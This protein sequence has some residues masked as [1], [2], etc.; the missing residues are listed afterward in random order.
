[1]T[2][3]I[4]VFFLITATMVGAM[5]AR[6]ASDDLANEIAQSLEEAPAEEPVLIAPPAPPEESAQ[7]GTAEAPLTTTGL[8]AE[9]QTPTGQFTTA[10]EVKPILSM[11][12]QSWVAVREYDGKD[13]VYFTNLLAWRCGVAQISYQINDGVETVFDAEPCQLDYATP[14]AMVDIE[15]FLPYIEAPLK[16]VESVRVHVIYDDLSED[17]VTVTRKEVLMP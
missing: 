14:N 16:S 12:K 8:Q 6:R 5:G 15:N 1:M 17:E 9:D 7:D 10:G 4:L 13:I 3:N 11:T 2:M